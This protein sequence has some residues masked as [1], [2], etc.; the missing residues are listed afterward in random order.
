MNVGPSK[1]F[2]RMVAFIL[3]LGTLPVVFLGSFSYVKSAMISREKVIRGNMSLLYQT[4]MRVEQ[5]LKTVESSVTQLQTS[6]V[7]QTMK[8]RPLS[9]MEFQYYNELS[10]RLH[11]LQSYENGVQDVT[12]VNLTRDWIMNNQMLAPFSSLSNKETLD[13]HLQNPQSAYWLR[14]MPAERIPQGMSTTYGVNF[15]KKLPVHAQTLKPTGMFIAKIPSL[16][17]NKILLNNDSLGTTMILDE[18]DRVIASV[19][20]TDLGKDLSGF[21]EAFLRNGKAQEGYFEYDFEEQ[22]SGITYRKSS[23]NGWSYV[24]IIPISE[25]TKESRVIG[26]ITLSVSLGIVLVILAGSFF[27][28]RRMYHPIKQLVD[29]VRGFAYAATYE[30]QKTDEFQFIGGRFEKLKDTQLKLENQIQTQVQFLR[31]LFILKLFQG[32]VRQQEIQEKLALYGYS[33][34]WKRLN[35]MSVQIDTL[36]DT[37]Y[38]ERDRDLLLFAISNIVSEL[39]PSHRRVTPILFED[40]QVTIIGSDSENIQDVKAEVFE[41]AERIQSTVNS[42]LGLAVSIGVSDSYE[43]IAFTPA[44]Y[45]ESVEALRYRMRLSEASILLHE[46]VQPDGGQTI[47]FPEQIEADLI[48]AVKLA[49]IDK[50]DELLDDFLESVFS[51][52][53]DFRAYQMTLVRLLVDLG[54]IIEP[55]G[56]SLITMHKG[57]ESLFEQLFE[58]KTAKEMK[59]WF[60]HTI[61]ESIVRLLEEHRESQYRKISDQMLELIHERYHTDLTLES[62]AKVLNYHPNYIKRVFRGEMGVNFSDYLVQY[63]MNLAKKWL[64][65]T[66]M[67]VSEIAERVGY[68]SPQNFIRYFRKMEG[69]TPGQ[70]REQNH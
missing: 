44:S 34:S 25:I 38:E 52:K 53:L 57:D 23:Y 59:I 36:K 7:I 30:D 16:E 11:N 58:L 13:V 35:V 17:L 33:D 41:M 31:E 60:R 56:A 6:S 8:D 15:I 12:L 37:R 45:Q 54:R 55:Y 20:E 5:L 9:Q 1:Y 69:V 19:R 51:D 62:C 24:Y 70:Y 43:D 46:D 2:I 63:R 10:N 64:L 40:Y 4:E 27:L 66:D 3:L 68:S 32:K 67:K 50:A 39:I 42:V 65:E 14:E 26:W 49:D 47:R 18:D 22:K 28:A 21:G 48:D 29:T 61:I